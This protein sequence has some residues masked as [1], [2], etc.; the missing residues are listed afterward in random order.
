MT[1]S[2]RLSHT[3]VAVPIAHILGSAFYLYSYCLGF[4]ADL[5]VHASAA[6]L[7][8]VSINDMVPVYVLSLVIPLLITIARLSSP[9]PYALDRINALPAEQR[10]DGQTSFRKFRR[11]VMGT[12][13][14]A[15]V[16]CSAIF[17]WGLWNND[18][19]PYRML[20]VGLLLPGTLLWMLFCER[21]GYSN[22]TYE[23][24]AIV[25]NFL[26]ALFCVGAAHGQTDRFIPYKTAKNS[27]TA[28]SRAVVLRQL[29]GKFLAI[30]PNNSR[31]LIADDC[32]V[33]FTIPAPRGRSPYRVISNPNKPV[34]SPKRTPEASKSNAPTAKN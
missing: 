27:H 12:A 34:L 2:E 22:W 14:F 20:W 9:H 33:K 6:D 13:I 10:V 7:V 29:S 21:R 5:V 17:V 28:C 18:Q 8:S 24:G 16:V 15:F 30:M 3:L 23:A 1:S 11:L 4:G 31:A 32:K 19:F 26:I 25:S